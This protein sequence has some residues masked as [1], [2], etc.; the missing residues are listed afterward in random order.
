MAIIRKGKKYDMNTM[1]ELVNEQAGD[2]IRV[3]LDGNTVCVNS[4]KLITFKQ[5]GVTCTECQIKGQFF[6]KEK[7]ITKRGGEY[8]HLNLYAVDETGKEIL[9]TKDHII[10]RSSGGLDDIFNYQPMCAICNKKKANKINEEMRKKKEKE[11]K[12]YSKQKNGNYALAEALQKALQ[13][14]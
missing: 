12:S 11:M 1:L 9:M 7:H 14:D 3:E 6:V 13:K 2:P 10:P 8:F 4:D 5:K